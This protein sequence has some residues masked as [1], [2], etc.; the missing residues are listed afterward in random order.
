M[1]CVVLQRPPFL[2]EPLPR[3]SLCSRASE[4]CGRRPV[5]LH[6][7]NLDPDLRKPQP[8]TQCRTHHEGV[9][10][11]RQRTRTYPF[12]QALFWAAPKPPHTYTYTPAHTQTAHLQA[13]SNGLASHHYPCHLTSNVYILSP[14]FMQSSGCDASGVSKI[15]CHLFLVLLPLPNNWK[16]HFLHMLPSLLPICFFY[17]W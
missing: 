4:D 12:I 7:R 16:I 17:I 13:T 15:V 11:I 8:W 5:A 9:R 2:S 10:K 1:T 6:Q 14:I 3:F